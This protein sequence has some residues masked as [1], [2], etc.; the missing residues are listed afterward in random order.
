MQLDGVGPD[1]YVYTCV[2][3][4]CANV[5]SLTQGML[6]HDQ[7]VR[8]CFDKK[9]VVLNSL[10]DLYSKCRRLDEA[11]RIFCKSPD[12]DVVSWSTMI[13]GYA[14]SGH[15]SYALDLFYTMEGNGIHPDRVSYLS[16]L[17]ACCGVGALSL[18]KVIHSKIIR[19]GCQSDLTVGN[20]LIDMYVKCGSLEEAQKIFEHLPG[21]DVVSWA[22]MIAAYS[23]NARGFSAV[24]CFDKMREEGI[25]LDRVT[26]LFVLKACGGVGALRKG[27]VVHEYI[28]R[29]GLDS[30]VV[31]GSTVIDMYAKCGSF[32]EAHA[33]L[34]RLKRRNTV[35]WNALIGGYADRGNFMMATSCFKRMLSEGLQP[36]A[37]TFTS[38]L[39]AC[40]H[41]GIV[42]DGY[43]YFESMKNDYGITPITDHLFC[44]VDLFS[45]AGRLY[46]ARE[47]LNSIPSVRHDGSGWMSLLTACQKYNDADVGRE[48]F[49]QIKEL[50]PS[51]ASCYMLMSKI[52]A[53]LQM[54]DKFAEIQEMRKRA[55][56]WRKPGQAWIEINEKV[57]EFLVSEITHQ[58]LDGTG[59][60]QERLQRLLRKEG[61]V[62][63]LDVMADL[64]Q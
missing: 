56:A 23:E 35:S 37:S 46:D 61:Y 3:R 57:H 13:A 34:D 30:D 29:G 6:L 27:R 7:L 40:S 16:I 41:A 24:D 43:E 59:P 51:D 19:D 20:T 39:T 15:A 45:R 12:P 55:H 50:D 42:E 60:K 33:A 62:A 26:F 32:N 10:V 14:Q 49:D 54:W 31:V 44:L 22:T 53:N 58:E 38:I 4:A 48:C 36:I 52:Y 8:Q 2:L 17:K 63:V 1:E 11:Y 21:R 25:E 64:A 28:I 47:V 5:G 18:G 9:L